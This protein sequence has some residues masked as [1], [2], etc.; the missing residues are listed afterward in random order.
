MTS[1]SRS[2]IQISTNIKKKLRPAAWTAGSGVWPLAEPS[3]EG[4]K[5]ATAQIDGFGRYTS[6]HSYSLHTKR[7]PRAKSEDAWKLWREGTPLDL[8]DP[9][10]EGSHSKTEVT[11][12][13]HIALL[14]VQD[15]LDARP[16][17][18][19]VVLMLNSNSS[20]LSLPQQ[21]RFLGR[22]RTRS[23]IFQALELDQCTSK[24]IYEW[25][26]NEASIMELD[27]R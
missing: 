18:A 20:M 17:I 13:I 24:S 1:T 3:Q 12:C 5:E 4:P 23:N 25:S 15:D 10:L 26:V 11:R 7:L 27:T 21:P 9:T 6:R 2:L 22:S 16:S 14:C 8:M 19:T